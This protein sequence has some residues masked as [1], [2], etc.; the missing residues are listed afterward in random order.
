MGAC[1][2]YRKRKRIEGTLND[3]QSMA[4]LKDPLSKFMYRV[5]PLPPTLKESVWLIGALSSDDERKYVGEMI[6]SSISFVCAIN[7]TQ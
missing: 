1:N 7:K 6:L 4:G 3:E 2:P 5:F